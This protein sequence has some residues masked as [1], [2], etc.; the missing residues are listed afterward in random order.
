MERFSR[1]P[2]CASNQL[3]NWL[4]LRNGSKTVFQYRR[5]SLQHHELRSQ[6]RIWASVDLRQ[7]DVNG[8]LKR[9]QKRSTAIAIRV[10]I[11]Q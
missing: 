2:R 11:L 7:L 1:R 5:N 10:G 3:R 8:G 6:F 9:S 4:A